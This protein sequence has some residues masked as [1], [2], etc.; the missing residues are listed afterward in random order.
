MTP[1][2]PDSAVGAMLL[3]TA[4]AIGLVLVVEAVANLLR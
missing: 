1:R 3:L 2:P 4:L